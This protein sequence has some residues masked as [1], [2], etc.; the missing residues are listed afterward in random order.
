MLVP[1][2]ECGNDISDKAYA[3]PNCGNPNLKSK[4]EGAVS[5]G[6]AKAKNLNVPAKAKDVSNKSKIKIKEYNIIARAAVAEHHK[7][8]DLGPTKKLLSSF[9]TKLFIMLFTLLLCWLAFIYQ[10][11][12]WVPFN[13]IEGLSYTIKRLFIEIHVLLNNPAVL[14]STI[15]QL[16]GTL[17]IPISLGFLIAK[18]SRAKKPKYYGFLLGCYVIF[19]ILL[20][21]M[22]SNEALLKSVNQGE[23]DAQYDQGIMLDNKR[24][25]SE[26]D[27]KAVRKAAQQ[28]QDKSLPPA[29]YQEP[30]VIWT[31]MD[32]EGTNPFAIVTSTGS[33]YY[34]KLV[35]GLSGA[36]MGIFVKGGQKLE[37]LVPTGSYEMRY[38]EGKTWR[39]LDHLF[40]PD[41]LTSYQKSESTL[42]FTV[43]DGY[44]SGYSVELI[45]QKAGNMETKPITASSF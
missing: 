29:V 38:A 24:G 44:Y 45:Q 2:K 36:E 10:Q 8:V 13:T 25:V 39:G 4:L 40:G 35:D 22:E 5:L 7:R 14:G 42:A 33:D 28:D 27:A 17:I 20:Y 31:K 30:G 11:N 16:V 26:N 18:V 1:C 15:A 23:S 34:L 12:A 21:S 32:R 3:C 9:F 6:V 43:S 37:V 19:P 41:N